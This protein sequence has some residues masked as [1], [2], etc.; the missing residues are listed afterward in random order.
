MKEVIWK[1]V[2]TPYIHL[3][4][5]AGY[6]ALVPISYYFGLLSSVTFV[7]A[8][9][10]WALVE[11][12]LSTYQAAVVAKKQSDDA[13]VSDVIDALDDIKKDDDA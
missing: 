4:V 10:I 9:S 13:D 2:K 11:S 8:L 7:S 3:W 1:C 12:R 5:L 6:I